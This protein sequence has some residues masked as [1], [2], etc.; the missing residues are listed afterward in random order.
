VASLL[1]QHNIIYGRGSIIN[2]SAWSLEVEVQFYCLAPVLTAVFSISSAIW[3]RACF[4]AVMVALPFMRSFVPPEIAG[5]FNSLPMHL[6]FFVAGF[7][8][9]DI[10]LVNWREA[11]TRSLVWDLLS[12]I[13]WPTLVTII[14]RRE[15]RL[16]V[17]PLMFLACVAAFKGTISSWIL[18]R[19]TIITIGGMCYSMYLIHY[20]VISA[21]GHF[22]SRIPFGSDFVTRFSLEALVVIPALL[23]TTAI[24]FIILER[25]CMDPMW[26]AKLGEYLNLWS[27]RAGT[28]PSV[29]ETA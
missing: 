2:F 10:F 12:V 8:L 6:E 27:G 4:I 16:L 26:F 22:S 7:L 17:A 11:P 20:G 5:R 1:Y 9:A 19:R 24:V 28:K 29:S 13:V 18:S 21:V 15:L 14:L 25:P 23:G 3:R